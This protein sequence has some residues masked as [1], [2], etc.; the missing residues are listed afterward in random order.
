MKK[1]RATYV[2]GFVLVIPKKNLRAYQRL[3]ELAGE[4]WRRHGALDYKECIGDDLNPKWGLPFPKLVK[5]KKGE[6]V[7]FSY[8]V[9][10][11]RAHR[12]RVNAKVMQDPLMHDPKYKDKPMPFDMK[13][14]VYGGFK[15]LVDA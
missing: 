13:R 9:Y 12:D 1:E 3:A 6:T 5:L 7:V 4:V 14:M 10:K 15:V 2:D 8:I 11:S